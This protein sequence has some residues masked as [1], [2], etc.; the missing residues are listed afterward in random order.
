MDNIE[1]YFEKYKVLADEE[2]PQM[3][4]NE[5]DFLARLH[6]CEEAGKVRKRRPWTKALTFSILGVAAAVTIALV[7]SWYGGDPRNPSEI[8]VS[9]YRKDVAPL[10]AEVQE[11]EMKSDV[12]REMGVS[13]V[14]E[15]LLSSSED[16]VKSL[17]GL[18]D[19]IRMDATMLYCDRQL[20]CIRD[21]F[22][23]CCQAYI[24]GVPDVDDSIF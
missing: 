12:C 9:N 21:L 10:L 13:S 16:F 18:D 3:R 15:E 11:M 6:Q 1:K 5:Q 17:D 8:F 14:I 4:T 20:D 24:S 2:M 23:E 19:S 22:R 7:L